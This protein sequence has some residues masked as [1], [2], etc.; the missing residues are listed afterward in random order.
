MKACTVRKERIA[1]TSPSNNSNTNRPLSHIIIINNTTSV[2]YTYD[3][4]YTYTKNNTKGLVIF[5]HRAGTL[6]V[7]KSYRVF[8]RNNVDSYVYRS[9]LNPLFIT[10]SHTTRRAKLYKKNKNTKRLLTLKLGVRDL[11]VLS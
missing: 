5:P 9:C 4:I 6:T 1:R 2:L 8:F 11:R 3:I 10:I 7:I